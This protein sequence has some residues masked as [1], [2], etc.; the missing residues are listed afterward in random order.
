MVDYAFLSLAQL[1]LCSP[2]ALILKICLLSEH[3]I[4]DGAKAWPSET[5][6]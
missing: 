5:N 4:F 1:A 3:L 2:L 6:D